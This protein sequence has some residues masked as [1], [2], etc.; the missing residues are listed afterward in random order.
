MLLLLLPEMCMGISQ[1]LCV[2][3]LQPSIAT[4]PST[5]RNVEPDGPKLSNHF[6]AGFKDL[7]LKKVQKVILGS[8]VADG[9][10]AVKPENQMEC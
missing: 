4:F 9:C 6:S 2:L 5:K 3:P 8:S 7:V 1:I 10:K